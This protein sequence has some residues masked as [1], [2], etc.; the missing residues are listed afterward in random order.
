V[1]ESARLFREQLD[2]AP[3]RRRR[4][5]RVEQAVDDLR[6]LR[7]EPPVRPR[8][9][10]QSLQDRKILGVHTGSKAYFPKAENTAP[11]RGRVRRI[12]SRPPSLRLTECRVSPRRRRE[13]RA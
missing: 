4:R 8:D 12:R 10:D 6:L 7:R 13:T 3:L 1:G 11:R 2:L 9:A 5:E